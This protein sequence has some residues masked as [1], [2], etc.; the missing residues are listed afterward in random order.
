MNKK[1]SKYSITQSPLYRITSKK[2][3]AELLGIKLDQL[4]DIT[5]NSKKFYKVWTKNTLKW[6]KKKKIF[7][8][9]ARDVEESRF[10]LKK[11][12]RKLCR[13][14]SR[15][16]TP[17][18]LMSGK[19]GVSYADNARYHVYNRYFLCTDISK[20][21]PSCSK[22]YV[23]KFFKNQLEMPEDVAWTITD[24]VTF[25]G[26]LPTG[27][28]TSQIIGYWAY[29]ITFSKIQK[30]AEKYGI[31]MTLYVDDFTFSSD[32]PIPE[33]F[34]KLIKQRLSQVGLH[35]N[36]EKNQYFYPKD[37]KK[38][39]GSVITPDNKLHVPNSLRYSIT[40]ALKG[41]K[42]ED[43]SKQIV[44]KLFGKLNAARQIEPNFYEGVYKR[45]KEKYIEL[46]FV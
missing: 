24:L 35:I 31:K 43:L 42:I 26:H 21:Y 40:E 10:L 34:D 7:Y 41:N 32:K 45:L 20:F 3:L 5:K 44:N 9:K 30:S 13:L 18:W 14:M 22:E 8:T 6:D 11:V 27:A 19:K 29:S 17:D 2:K 12:Q 33:N 38:I 25:N 37:H 4:V 1:S 16:E 28:P 36:D 39:T 23:F 15:I 46:N